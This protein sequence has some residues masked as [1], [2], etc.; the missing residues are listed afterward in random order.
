MAGSNKKKLICQRKISLRAASF[1]LF[2]DGI[3]ARKSFKIR[4]RMKGKPR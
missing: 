1:Q 2:V 4:I 3:M